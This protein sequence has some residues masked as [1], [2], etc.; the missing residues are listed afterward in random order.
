MSVTLLRIRVQFQDGSKYDAKITER[1][2]Q[3]D[4][5]VIGIK[6]SDMPVTKLGDSSELGSGSG[7]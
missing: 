4:V 1:D 3:S 5:A 7:L 2:P 6:T